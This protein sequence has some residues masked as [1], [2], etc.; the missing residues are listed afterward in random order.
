MLLVSM[1]WSFHPVGA[2]FDSRKETLKTMAFQSGDNQDL[3]TRKSD[4]NKD[5][6]LDGVFSDLMPDSRLEMPGMLDC[7]SIGD[8]VPLIGHWWAE[9]QGQCPR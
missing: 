8:H 2:C 9:P 1:V 3:L 6:R 5:S 7:C 4:Q